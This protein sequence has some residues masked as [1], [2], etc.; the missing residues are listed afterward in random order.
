MS[1]KPQNCLYQDYGSIQDRDKLQNIIKDIQDTAQ[2]Y[3]QR[4]SEREEELEN[5]RWLIAEQTYPEEQAQVVLF[6]NRQFKVTSA[7]ELTGRR[8][9]ASR[10]PSRWPSTVYVYTENTLPMLHDTDCR[11][12]VSRKKGAPDGLRWSK[13][14]HLNK[15]PLDTKVRILSGQIKWLFVMQADS[16]RST[17]SDDSKNSVV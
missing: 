12:R 15:L 14:L 7:K 2:T 13:T 3:I 9:I 5:T 6:D 17:E 8:A 4:S 10:I 1:N 11:V 16:R